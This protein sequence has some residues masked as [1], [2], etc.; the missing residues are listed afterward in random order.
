MEIEKK[1]ETSWKIKL[2]HP[3]E[4][5][6]IT[7]I[8]IS[9]EVRNLRIALFNNGDSIN[10]EMNK[11]E[12][13]NFLSLLKA[14]KDVVVG[15]TS[16]VIDGELTLLEQDNPETEKYKDKPSD[17]YEEEKEFSSSTEDTEEQLNPK[18]WD[19]W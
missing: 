7:S 19:P 10:T 14:F 11:Q 1:R 4:Y 5:I 17:Q 15:E 16:Y 3:D 12:F 18:E 2:K 13:Y 6:E 8:E 9:G